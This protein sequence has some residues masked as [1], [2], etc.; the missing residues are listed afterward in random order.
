MKPLFDSV[1]NFSNSIFWFESIVDL[2]IKGTI[3]LGAA[4]IF[5]QIWKN[6]SAAIR[7]SILC[8]A[9]LGI[10]IVPIFSSVLPPWE[11][12][13]FNSALPEKPVLTS[14]NEAGKPGNVSDKL[15]EMDKN[16]I[17]SKQHR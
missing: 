1:L 10:L 16:S 6:S 17:A 11:I 2:T 9:I 12:P 4:I 15:G 5:S 13:Y 7:H 14:S 3:I 8:L